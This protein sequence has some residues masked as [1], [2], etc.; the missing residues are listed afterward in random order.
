VTVRIQLQLLKN[1]HVTLQT[2]FH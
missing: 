2:L 1:S